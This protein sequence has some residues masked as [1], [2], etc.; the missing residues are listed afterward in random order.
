MDAETFEQGAVS[1]ATFDEGG[2]FTLP[3]GSRAGTFQAEGAGAGGVRGW[4]VGDD[5]WAWIEL[6]RLML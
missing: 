3:P 5:R 2:S 1:L 6:G 4:G